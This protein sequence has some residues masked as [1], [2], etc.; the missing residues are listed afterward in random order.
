[1][2]MPRLSIGF[3]AGDRRPSLV[4]SGEKKADVVEHPEV[5]DHVGLL[6]DGPPGG[7]GLPF[8]QSSDEFEVKSFF[9]AVATSEKW[10]AAVRIMTRGTGM[11]SE[12]LF[13]FVWIFPGQLGHA[14]PSFRSARAP[15]MVKIKS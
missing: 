5:F 7:A 15:K 8:V 2:F 10:S 4:A 13:D 14:G 11:A 3:V 1:M 9:G 12:F 6:V